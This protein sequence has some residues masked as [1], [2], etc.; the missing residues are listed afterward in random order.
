MLK[1]IRVEDVRLG[2]YIQGF[3]GAWLDHPFWRT[4]FVLD[5]PQ[6]LERIHASAVRELW[7]DVSK[8]QDIEA[9]VVV[10]AEAVNEAHVEALNVLEQAVQRDTAPT[11]Q[12]AEMR[13]AAALIR[14]ARGAMVG[15]FNE[16]RMGKAIDSTVARAVAEEI[17]DSVF[18]HG[19]A[20]ISLAR[21]KSADDYTYMHSVAVCALMVALAKQLG[22]SEEEA[23]AAGFA[24]LL[25]DIGKLDIPIEIL[26]KPG[27]L[28]EAE[29]TVVRNHP[30][31]GWE[32]LKKAGIEHAAALDVCLHHHE[33]F[34]G[35]G[36]PD[37]LEGEGI[38][39]MAR[40]GAICDV[41]DA[42]TSNRPYKEGWDPAASLKQMASWKGDFD[43]RLFQAFVRSLGIYPVGSLV[44]L[45][46][47]RLAVVVEQS[48]GNL[49]LPIVK[50]VYST[51]Q[52]E[53]VKPERVD[54]SVP[55]CAV[56]ILQREDPAQWKIPDLD[57]IWSEVPGLGRAKA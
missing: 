1:R 25:H 46:N 11:T 19:G 41:Y 7:I 21:I 56:N 13:R 40:M 37:G 49:L 15:M 44:Q 33:R 18:R 47:G 28:S 2:M 53:R 43:P 54:L 12:Q 20:L 24:G 6:D 57:E 17:S 16:V 31:K 10:Q 30:R 39:V 8:G 27:K 3:T 29:Y 50:T 36:Y 4:K 55:G 32:R 34:V 23:R 48:Q 9:T 45:S 5:D 22:M 52:G 51:R 14:S 35:K 26:N 42:I 38:S